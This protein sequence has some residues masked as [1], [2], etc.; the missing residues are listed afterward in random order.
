MPQPQRKMQRYDTACVTIR[1]TR[2]TNNIVNIALRMYERSGY[3]VVPGRFYRDIKKGDLY[4]LQ[5]SFWFLRIW[6]G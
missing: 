4:K 3:R 2:V 1:G 6:I 5:F